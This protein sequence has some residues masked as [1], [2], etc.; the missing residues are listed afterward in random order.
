M[1]IHKVGVLE[2]ISVH[3]CSAIRFPGAPRICLHLDITFS[4]RDDVSALI[5]CSAMVAFDFFSVT[6]TFYG[7]LFILNLDS[8]K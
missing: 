2:V 4:A 3:L 6:V 1:N 8:E 5:G 7:L